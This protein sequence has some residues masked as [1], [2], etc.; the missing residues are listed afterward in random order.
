MG[1]ASRL[2]EL[3]NVPMVAAEMA[4]IL[5]VQTDEFWQD[6]TLPILENMRRHLRQL[7]KLIEPKDRKI[8]YTDFEDEIGAAVD[9]TLPTIGAG[10]DKARFLMKVRHF[11]AQH[12]NHITIQKLRRNQQLTPQDLSELERIF[13][14]ES[15]GS[16]EDLE[17][18]RS[19]GG[20]GLFVRS[21]VGLDREAAKQALA[22]FM[23]GRTLFANQI[24][25][26]DLAFEVI[27][28]G[29]VT[30]M[31]ASSHARISALLK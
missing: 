1:I 3:G 27:G 14:A 7:V 4:L 2:E 31:P 11:L 21:L 24:E 9:V 28:F 22:E 13:L 16:P 19:E 30:V 29:N 17:R 20:L 12:E 5:E 8:V 26:I 25:F 10:T 6:V 15:V 18:I 23:S